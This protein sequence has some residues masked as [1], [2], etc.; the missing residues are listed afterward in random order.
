[1]VKLSIVPINYFAPL[2]AFLR[3][4]RKGRDRARI[5]SLQGDRLAGFLAESIRAVFEA[6]QRRIDFRNQL[7]L[8]VARAKLELALGFRSGAIGK[9]RIGR[10]LRLEILD[11]LAT[12]AKNVL[13]PG[14]QLA[15]KIFA[16]PLVHKGFFVGRPV[17]VWQV[18]LHALSWIRTRLVGG[19]VIAAARVRGK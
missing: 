12:L 18:G 4:D 19:A 15:A 1:M 13:F 8:A 10:G 14:H 16:L 17:A 7:A 5:Q 6:P 2:V 9:I 11:R 3:L